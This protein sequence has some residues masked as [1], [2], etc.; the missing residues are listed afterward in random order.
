L[1]YGREPTDIPPLPPAETDQTREFRAK[2]LEIRQR[3]ARL[4]IKD[5]SEGI[6][7]ARSRLGDDLVLAEEAGWKNQ[8]ENKQVGTW[9][10]GRNLTTAVHD[11]VC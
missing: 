10:R 4:S 3:F 6:H 7:K 11:N 1:K 9:C 2:N 8:C 5:A